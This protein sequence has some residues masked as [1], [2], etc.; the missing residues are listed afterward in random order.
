MGMTPAEGREIV[1]M[2]LDELTQRK[3]ITVDNYQTI[4]QMVEPKL[5]EY[6]NDK[7]EGN[8]VSGVLYRF[9]DDEYIDI[10]YLIYRD[11]KTQEW[12]AEYMGVDVSTIKRNKKRLITK[13]YELLEV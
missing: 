3:L 8:G 1:K 7:G 11:G 9:I 4:L 5:Y 2:T 10:I 6:F 13:I 12:I